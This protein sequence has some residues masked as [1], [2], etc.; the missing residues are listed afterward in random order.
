MSSLQ[1]EIARAD[2][3][4]RSYSKVVASV[5]RKLAEV[6]EFEAALTWCAG[7][8]HMIMNVETSD[9]ASPLCLRGVSA[10]NKLTADA[11]QKLCI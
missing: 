1:K 11:H 9:V 10:S 3:A 6:C 8:D 2:D 7:D 5:N 4:M